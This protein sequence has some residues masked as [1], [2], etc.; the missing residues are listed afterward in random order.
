VG[1][2]ERNQGRTFLRRGGKVKR[3]EEYDFQP[4]EVMSKVIDRSWKSST[5]EIEIRGNSLGELG[6]SRGPNEKKLIAQRDI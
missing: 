6:I 1:V 4:T 3:L 2:A 5:Q